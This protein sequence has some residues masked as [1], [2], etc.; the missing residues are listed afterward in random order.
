MPSR[1]AIKACLK[2]STRSCSNLASSD[3]IIFDAL[4]KSCFA[5]IARRSACSW[6][7]IKIRQT[8]VVKCAGPLRFRRV[9]YRPCLMEC[10]LAVEPFRVSVVLS[11]HRHLHAATKCTT[12]PLMQRQAA[13]SIGH[14]LCHKHNKRTRTELT[15]RAYSST[16]TIWLVVK[17]RY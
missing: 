4:S 7:T 10:G 2:S 13:T 14:C 1:K 12:A 6:T 11:V 17:H 9:S 16:M 8:T 15:S 5:S 3:L